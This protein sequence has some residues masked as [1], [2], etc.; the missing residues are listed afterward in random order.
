[1]LLSS[2][3]FYLFKKKMF[4]A[5]ACPEAL[6]APPELSCPSLKKEDP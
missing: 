2:Q 3:Q 6:L 1:M 5:M 4:T